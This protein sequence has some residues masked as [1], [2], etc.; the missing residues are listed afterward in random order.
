MEL[1]KRAKVILSCNQTDQYE[2][3][4][5]EEDDKPSCEVRIWE[6]IK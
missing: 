6:M 5:N 1:A 2:S 3:L 4:N